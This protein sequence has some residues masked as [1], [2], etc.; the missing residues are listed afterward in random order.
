MMALRRFHRVWIFPLLFAAV[1]SPSAHAAE[2]P[3]VRAITAFVRL[4][5]AQYKTQIHDAL[6]MLRQAKAAFQQAGYEVQGLRI[7]TQPSPEYVRGLSRQEALAFFREY[8]DLV[9]T[10]DFDAAIGPAMFTDPEDAQQ[11]ELLAEI[12]SRYPRLNASLTV[13]GEEGVRWKAV[14]AAARVIKYLEEHSPGSIGNFNFSATAMVPAYTPFYP[15]AYHNGPGRKFALALQSAN[16]VSEAFT[17]AKSVEAARQSLASVLGEHARAIEAIARRVEK[18]SG[19]EYVGI[20]LSPAPL[21]EVSIAGAI[22]RLTGAKF[23]TS[24]TMT[25]AALITGV[26]HSLPVKRT[27]YSGL[28]VPVLEDSVIAERWSDGTLSLDALLAYSAVC[29]TGLDTIPLPGDVSEDQLARIIG[30]MA[31]LAV[32]LR[33]P[34]SARLMPVRG[35]KPGDWTEFD[36]PFIVNARI[37]PLR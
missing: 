13:A 10:E 26:L 11:A 27:G 15:G 34:L 16:V 17:S 36:D 20:D 37:Q 8:E 23:G 29:G 33:K 24:G 12:L 18:E 31:T 9:K 6:K 30:D 22:E 35:K 14:R 19:W 5:R 4:D 25:A 28:M 7:A 3:K 32:K 21:R 1:C 2:K